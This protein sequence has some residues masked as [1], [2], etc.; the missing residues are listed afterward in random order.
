MRFIVMISALVALAACSGRDD[1]GN[2]RR[3]TF[4]GIAFNARLSADREDRRAFTITVRPA[5]ANVEAAQE[6]GRYEAVKYCLRN[7]GGSEAEW[8]VGPDT[9]PEQLRI[10]DDTVTLTGRCTE[11]A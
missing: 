3:P 8:T 7:Y 10:V 2:P 6:A 9:P 1:E 5:S 4:D 11:R